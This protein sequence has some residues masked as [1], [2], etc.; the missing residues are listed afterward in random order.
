MV[1][2][3]ELYNQLIINSISQLVSAD[4]N[5]TPDVKSRL[6]TFVNQLKACSW[7]SVINTKYEQFKHFKLLNIY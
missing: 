4:C 3:L 5:D 6:G 2:P 1:Y 7:K